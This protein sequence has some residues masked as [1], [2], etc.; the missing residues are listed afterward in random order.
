L[1]DGGTDRQSLPRDF[2]ATSLETR[3]F[4]RQGSSTFLKETIFHLDCENLLNMHVP[5]CQQY[6]KTQWITKI[7]PH[8][9]NKRWIFTPSFRRAKIALLNWPEYS[10]V[11][12]E[13][14]IRILV[15]TPSEFEEYV[16]FCGYLFPVIYLPQD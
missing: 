15:V 13:S 6:E 3:N 14:T 11:N 8:K 1:D 2:K 16:M 10:I 12:E 7:A 4:I 5:G 9:C